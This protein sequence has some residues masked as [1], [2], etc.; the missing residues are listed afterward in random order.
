MVF[1]TAQID[2][3]L[4]HLDYPIMSWSIALATNRLNDI[5]S[6]SVASETRVAAILDTL[7]AIEA[8]RNS[9]RSQYGVE[10]EGT[11]LAATAG[12]R[13][14]QGSVWS[15]LQR[16]YNYWRSQLSVATSIPINGGSGFRVLLS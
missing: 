7:D 4:G 8:E 13:Y 5:S 9:L 6:L 16:D 3:V 1:S 10:A 2:S 12:R 15:D 11:S 14:F